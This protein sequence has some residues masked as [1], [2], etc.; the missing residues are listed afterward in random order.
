MSVIAWC[1]GRGRSPVVSCRRGPSSP[2]KRRRLLARSYA[3][4]V[5][6]GGDAYPVPVG[7]SHAMRSLRRGCG[8]TILS[9]QWM[10]GA[11]RGRWGPGGTVAQR[12]MT[13][14]VD[15]CQPAVMRAGRPLVGPRDRAPTPCCVRHGQTLCFVVGLCCLECADHTGGTPLCA[16]MA[17]LLMMCA[18]M[19]RHLGSLAAHASRRVWIVLTT[20]SPRTLMFAS[21]ANDV[22]EPQ[23]LRVYLA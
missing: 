21:Q 13:T 11:R 9:Y 18:R 16:L 7:K 1:D 3:C 20:L 4:R 12:P 14:I 8:E 6:V 19:R 17:S 22:C 23:Q 2:R 5:L 15:T 10:R